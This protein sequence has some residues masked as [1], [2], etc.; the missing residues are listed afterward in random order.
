[1]KNEKFP[2]YRNKVYK[3]IQE[4]IVPKYDE[5]DACNMHILPEYVTWDVEYIFT[6]TTDLSDRQKF[7]LKRKIDWS[8]VDFCDSFYGFYFVN[9]IIIFI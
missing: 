3:Y 2:E 4:E 6:L 1:M 7:I 9:I 8:L 5:I